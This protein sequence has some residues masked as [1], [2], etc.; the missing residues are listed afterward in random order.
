MPGPVGERAGDDVAHSKRDARWFSYAATRP[1]PRREQR[2][3]PRGRAWGELA[4]KMPEVVARQTGVVVP[5]RPS[6]AAVGSLGWTL[7]FEI[8][9]PVVFLALMP[10]VD[11]RVVWPDG[12]APQLLRLFQDDMRDGAPLP[13]L[14]TAVEFSVWAR[15]G[16]PVA[17]DVTVI[18]G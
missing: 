14:G 7:P 10:P 2:V 5:Y 18:G 6:K 13:E 9:G 12:G 11:Y 3:W 15:A 4:Q 17:S 1:W 16:Q 8:V